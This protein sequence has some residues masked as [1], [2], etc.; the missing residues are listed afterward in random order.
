M[1]IHN[2]QHEILMNEGENKNKNVVNR[3]FY[4]L[5]FYKKIM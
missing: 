4:N 5:F 3:H 2:Q 1:H